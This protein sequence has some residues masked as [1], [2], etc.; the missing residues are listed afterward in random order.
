M[1]YDRS[2]DKRIGGSTIAGILGLS[3]WASPHSIYL[4]LIGELPEKDKSVFERGKRLEPVVAKMF[5]AA[6]TDCDIHKIGTVT[7]GE[8]PFLIANIDR[9]VLDKN[10]IH[11]DYV[12]EIKTADITKF[13]EWGEEGTDEIPVEYLCQCLW[14]CGMLG[15]PECYIA[16]GFVKSG[17]S[18]ICG[19]KE[20]KVVADNSMF[21]KMKQAAVRFW[22]EHVEKR[23]PP[24]ITTADESTATYYKR[25]YPN[26][27]PDKW[28]GSDERLDEVAQRYLV[29][30]AELKEKERT[31]ETLKL[32]LIAAIGENEGIRT[33][34]GNFTYRASKPTFKTDWKSVASAMNPPAELIETNTTEQAGSRRFLA[35]NPGKNR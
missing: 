16:V 31:V 34:S 20:Y 32:K 24:E 7:D 8:E 14:Y 15:L 21:D 30:S 6:H 11:N 18:Q 10:H 2:K 23:V 28:A 17:T 35:P 12:L 1:T 19:Y 4:D 26:H 9:V 33:A 29:E 5:E 3:R 13:G 25:R 22:K 27:S